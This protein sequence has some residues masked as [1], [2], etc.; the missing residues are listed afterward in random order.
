MRRRRRLR[1]TS[2]PDRSSSCAETG[3]RPQLPLSEER[4]IDTVDRSAE[5]RFLAARLWMVP[6]A[7][8]GYGVS[9][10]AFAGRHP[11]SPLIVAI[12]ATASSMAVLTWMARRSLLRMHPLVLL[13]STVA[14]V[15]AWAV[16]CL[17]PRHDGNTSFAITVLASGLFLSRPRHVAILVLAV[18]SALVAASFTA[19]IPNPKTAG[20]AMLSATVVAWWVASARTR[21]T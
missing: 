14:A 9:E 17:D 16:T 15:H 19:C 2:R 13:G 12:G 21:R 3:G 5:M 6:V 11:L 8:A 4:A 18:T 7:Y 10:V 1:R 20:L